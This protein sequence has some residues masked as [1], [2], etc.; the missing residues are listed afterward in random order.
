MKTK[1][2]SASKLT[3]PG[4]RSLSLLLGLVGVYPLACVHADS[5]WVKPGHGER[6]LVSDLKA[7]EVG[8]ILTILVEESSSQVNSQS[9]KTKKSAEI[10]GKVNQFLFSPQAS[11][12]GTHNGELPAYG[13]QGDN[14][15]EGGGEIANRQS[16]STRLSV[17]VTDRLPNGNLVVQGVRSVSFSGEKFFMLLHGI[18]RPADIST[19]NTIAS[20]MIAEARVEMLSE[21]GITDAQKKGWLM[22]LND[23]LNPF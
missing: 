3:A 2:A 19:A 1:S 11:G 7:A 10:S 18:V 5:L 15:Y 9:T 14:S 13:F 16:I 21:G 12:F 22:R 20:G 4:F 6:S 23:L 8:D 17:I